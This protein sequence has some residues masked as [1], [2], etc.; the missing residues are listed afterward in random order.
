MT[1]V[2]QNLLINYRLSYS[3]FSKVQDKFNSIE[4][5]IN[6]NETESDINYIWN[7]TK[8]GLSAEDVVTYYF[9]VFDND[10]VSG[11]KS[12]KS[13]TFD[14][15]VPSLEEILTRADDTHQEAVQDF[16]QTLKDAQELKKILRK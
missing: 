6:K 8:L 2:L 12:A 1:M 14:V 3:K 5:P 10:N 16:K 7:L 4:I 9:E 11:P 13:S 15:R